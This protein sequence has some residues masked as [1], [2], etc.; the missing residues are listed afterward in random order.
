MIVSK[1]EDISSI[2][3]TPLWLYI[4]RQIGRNLITVEVKDLE[5]PGGMAGLMSFYMHIGKLSLAESRFTTLTT[6][7]LCNF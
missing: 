1:L 7:S 5:F 4:F 6:A 2:G 3:Q